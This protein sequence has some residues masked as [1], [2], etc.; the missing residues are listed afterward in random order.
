MG[1]PRVIDTRGVRV[2]EPIGPVEVQRL[3]AG[4]SRKAGKPR[5][6]DSRVVELQ[7]AEVTSALADG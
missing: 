3:K 1:E 4:Q 6:A 5:A 2:F 7:L